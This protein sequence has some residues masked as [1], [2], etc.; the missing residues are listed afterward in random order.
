MKFEPTVVDGAFLVR[1][2]RHVDERGFF[3]RSFCAEEF[4]ASG[5]PGQF[6]QCNV[7]FNSRRGTLR[8]MHYQRAPRAEGKLVRCTM[9][10]ALDVIVDLRKES[11]TYCRWA[12]VEISAE[13]RLALYVPPGVAHGFQTLVDGTELFY[14]MTDY[15]APQL[16]DGVRWNDPA[17]RIEWPIPNPILSARDA[18][19]ADFAV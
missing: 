13:N 18:S 10:A 12:A 1:L 7:S 17:F 4:P 8:G 5:L 16:A 11:P 6:V 14:Q 19:Y 3:A 9:G 2:E 15:Y